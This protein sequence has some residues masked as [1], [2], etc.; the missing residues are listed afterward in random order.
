MMCGP[1]RAVK[2]AEIKGSIGVNSHTARLERPKK[3]ERSV[4]FEL[5]VVLAA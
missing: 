1:E 2:A 4:G 3:A 5:G